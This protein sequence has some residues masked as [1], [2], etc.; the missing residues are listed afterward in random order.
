MERLDGADPEAGVQGDQSKHSSGGLTVR[1]EILYQPSFSLAVVSLERGESIMAES[2]A[3]ISMS[4]TIKLEAQMSGGGLFGALKS[5]VGGESLFRTTFTAESGPGE[6]TLA[7][8]T[9]GDILSVPLSGNRFFVQPGSYLA[10][11]PRLNIGVQGSV[12]GMLAGEGLFLLTV[13][14]NG[15]LLL[16]SFGAIHEKYLGPGEEYIVDTGH[17]VSFEDSVQYHLE[18]ATG[19]S[20]GLGGFLKGMVQSGLS[21]EGLVC[22]YR[23]PGRIYIQTRQFPSFARQ[24]LPFLPK[25]GG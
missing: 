22:R 12:R 10:G 5:A 8:S 21:G 20:Q 25:T 1:H 18:K 6:V 11:D 2:G 14:G 19:K 17:I 3:M 13:E 15:L 23:G 7:P 4:P 9:L 24:L 16:S